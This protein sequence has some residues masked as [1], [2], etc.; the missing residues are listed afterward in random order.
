VKRLTEDGT[1]AADT[2]RDYRNKLV[3]LQVL[4]KQII[5][6]NHYYIHRE[7]YGSLED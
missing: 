4:N 5:R 6:G 1:Y 7:R 3:E 2:A